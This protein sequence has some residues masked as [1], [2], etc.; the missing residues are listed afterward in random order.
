MQRAPRGRRSPAGLRMISMTGTLTWQTWMSA[1]SRFVLLLQFHLQTVLHLQSE[2]C[3]PPPVE[4]FSHGP[5]RAGEN[6]G[7]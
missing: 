1:S 4:D 7:L 6:S 3:D 5:I 2:R